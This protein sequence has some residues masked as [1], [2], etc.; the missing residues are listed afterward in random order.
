MPEYNMILIKNCIDKS[1]TALNDVEYL[2][3]D[4]RKGAALNRLYYAIFYMVQALA[5]KENFVTSKH[6]QL[7][8]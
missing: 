1:F 5:H 8:G 7:M 6:S 4:A 3:K 2:L